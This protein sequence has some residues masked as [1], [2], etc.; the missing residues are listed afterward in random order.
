M[1]EI[2]ALT[3]S[4]SVFKRVS[5]TLLAD[6]LKFTN[7]TQQDLSKSLCRVRLLDSDSTCAQSDEI[8]LDND[9]PGHS[10]QV[11]LQ[12]HSL[13]HYYMCQKSCNRCCHLGFL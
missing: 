4:T 3:A 7:N 6:S 10:D 8:D 12:C 9:A 5:E 1:V 11:P 2:M 13:Y